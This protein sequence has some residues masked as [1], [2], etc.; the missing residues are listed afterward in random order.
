M[1]NL[2]CLLFALFNVLFAVPAVASDQTPQSAFD[3][4]SG[5]SNDIYVI[6]ELNGGN[7]KDW[8]E[9]EATAAQNMIRAL[10]SYDT[11][12]HVK[13]KNG[14]TPLHYASRRG[15]HFLVEII[16]N[17]EIGVG[18]INAQDRYGLTPY[19]LSQLAI[20]DTLLF[21]HPEIKNPF[22]LVPYLVTRPYYENRD[23]YPKIHK[24]LLAHN[25]NPVPDD[26]KAYWLNNCSQKDDDLRNKVT[27]TSDLYTTLRVGSSKVERL[28]GQ[29][30]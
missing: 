8:A 16:L 27:T 7:E 23:P 15:F 1:Y 12:Q 21:C 4:I 22:V 10:H 5:F 30:H 14:R 3:V 6:G 9:K 2:F 26:A 17:H 25:A 13:D 28:L 20:A 18:W 29:R 19:A 24:L 11:V